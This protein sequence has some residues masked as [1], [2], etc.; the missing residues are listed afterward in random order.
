V[1]GIFDTGIFDTGIFDHEAVGGTG[2]VNGAL[3]RKQDDNTLA[4]TGEVRAN[5]GTLNAEQE[6]DSL[7]ATGTVQVKAEL[8][9]QESDDTLAATTGVRVAGSLSATAEDDT[10]VATIN[11][12]LNGEANVT[13]GDNTLSTVEPYFVAPSYGHWVKK[14]NRKKPQAPKLPDPVQAGEIVIDEAVLRQMEEE[15]LAALV[16]QKKTEALG[17]TE[18]LRATVPVTEGRATRSITLRDNTFDRVDTT[19]DVRRA[20]VTLFRP[21]Q[22]PALVDPVRGSITLRALGPRHMPEPDIRR[23]KTISRRRSPG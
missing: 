13:Q 18:L 1:T 4:A 16:L 8:S 17:T 9:A 5:R 20:V 14:Q 6:S 15:R 3:T 7:S 10:V 12:P 23:S 21:P 22:K 11:K 2:D 19:P